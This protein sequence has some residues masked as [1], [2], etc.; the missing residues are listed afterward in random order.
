MKTPQEANYP[1]SKNKLLETQ[2]YLTE[3]VDRGK[4]TN[5]DPSKISNSLS[6]TLWLSN[7]GWELHITEYYKEEYIS[8][9][10]LEG[11]DK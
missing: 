3:C 6:L 5:L 9:K 7:Y 1:S 8:L 4:F 2:Q 11:Y 10:P